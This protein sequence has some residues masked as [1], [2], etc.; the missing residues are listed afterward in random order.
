MSPYVQLEPKYTYTVG[1]DWIRWPFNPQYP[2]TESQNIWSPGVH[3]PATFTDASCCLFTPSTTLPTLGTAHNQRIGNKISLQSF[4]FRIYV[5]LAPEFACPNEGNP[6]SSNSDHHKSAIANDDSY[7]FP[8][9]WFKMRLFVIQ[10]DNS[11]DTMTPTKFGDWFFS[12]YLPFR[13][14]IVTTSTDPGTRPVSV[15]SKM[16]RQSTKWTGTFNILLDKC[17]TLYSNKP[18]ILLDYTIPLNYTYTW[19]DDGTLQT[20]KN[21]ICVLMPPLQWFTDVDPYTSKQYRNAFNGNW[22]ADVE[23]WFTFDYFVKT[24]FTDL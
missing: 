2:A 1:H 18:Q 7:T 23:K 5:N 22:Y 24:N 21:I 4:R 9:R 12:T 11:I 14:T 16:L 3:F 19:R 20:P 8:K 17:F 13:D 6:F 15:H 10:F